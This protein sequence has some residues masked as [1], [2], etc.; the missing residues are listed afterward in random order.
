[1]SLHTAQMLP[2]FSIS[3]KRKGRETTFNKLNANKIPVVP[4]DFLKRYFRQLLSI[5]P[6]GNC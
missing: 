6:C 4:L 1:V 3:S 5:F 2:D